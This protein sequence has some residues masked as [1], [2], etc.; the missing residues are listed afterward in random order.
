MLLDAAAALKAERYQEA[1]DAGRRVTQFDPNNF[2][3][4][5]CV[6]LASFHLQEW[7]DCED[8]Y[9][10]AADLKPELPAPWK[11]LVDLFGA[12]RDVKSKLEPLQKLVDINLRG[13]KLKKCQKW[14]AEVAA[15]AME[16]KMLTKDSPTESLRAGDS[17]QILGT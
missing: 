8:A 2:Q 17:I 7:E 6:G 1:Q 13:K 15:T 4:F 12:K 9:R 10:R 14:V 16:L 3:A 11:Y 5:M